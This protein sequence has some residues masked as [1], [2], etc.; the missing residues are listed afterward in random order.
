MNKLATGITLL[1]G[2]I[3]ML[4][5][6]TTHVVPGSQPTIQAAINVAVNGDTVLV[7]PGVYTENLDVQ[8]KDITI[9]SAGG[10]AQT[11]IDGGLL[12]TTVL[13]SAG[14]TR[15]SVLRGFTI[16]GGLRTGGSPG[17][18]GG[19]IRIDGSSPTIRDCVVTGN[20]SESYGGGI[21]AIGASGPRI[22]RCDLIGNHASGLSYASGGGFAAVSATAAATEIVDCTIAANDAVTRGGGIFAA[23]SPGLTI[24]SCRITRNVTAGTSGNLNGGAGVFLSLNSTAAV[25][26]CRIWANQSASDGGGV[27]WFNVTGVTFVNDTIVDNVGGGASGTATGAAYGSNVVSDFVNCILWNNGA[28]EFNFTGTDSSGVP[29][30]ANV[31]HCVVTGG[32]A[33]TGNLSSSPQL[34]NSGSGNHHLAASSPCID[35]GSSVLATLPATD[36]D[37]GARVL[38]SEADIGADEFDPTA[39]LHY[40]DVATLSSTSPTPIVYT[41]TNGPANGLFAVFFSLSGTRPGL[42]LFGQHV[43]LNPDGATFAYF[44]AGLLDGT[45]TGSAAL[46]PLPV[47]TALI[48]FTLS[49]VGMTYLTQ[50][51]FSNDENVLLVQ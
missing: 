12:G 49:S 5:A 3:G 19:G 40:A 7:L 16:T 10:A 28:T 45:G 34:L 11:T 39:T 23:Y 37:G 13:Y 30:S 14:S 2:P 35:A 46:P 26:N 27:K 21:G 44:L 31:D 1:L 17:G 24:D 22:E 36:M 43:P 51:G 4:C 9:E 32:Y 41:V 15:S 29:P 42:P 47:P 25:T 6:Q 50:F 48:G 33:G 18:V 38:L 8:G 20:T